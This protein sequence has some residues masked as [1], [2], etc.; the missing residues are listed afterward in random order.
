[1]TA[2]DFRAMALAFPDAH[3]AP[4]FDRASFRIGKKI[5]ATLAADGLSG[6]VRVAPLER[7]EAIMAEYPDAFFS[8]GG[9]TTK[10]C[11][12]GVKLDAVDPALLH[13]LMGGSYDH[14]AAKPKRVRKA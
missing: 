11:S 6:M 9:W 10:N 3:E 7:L 5:F 14:A 2:D 12:L 1:M 13:A 8:F 4:H